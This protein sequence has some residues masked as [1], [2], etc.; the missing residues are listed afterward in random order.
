MLSEREYLTAGTS[1]KIICP[2]WETVRLIGR[3]SF[4]AVYEIQRDVFGHKEKAALKVLSIPPYDDFIEALYDEAYDD[5]DISNYLNNYLTD[6]LEVYS[7]NADVQDH[8]NVVSYDNIHYFRHDD[9]F[10]WNIYIKMELLTPITKVLDN[11][12]SDEQV[13]RLGKD[14]CRALIFGRS[15]NIAHGDITL[16]NIFISNAGNHKLGDFGIKKVV[17]NTLPARC[18]TLIITRHRKCITTSATD[19]W[20]ISTL[21]A[22]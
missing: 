22:W 16:Q 4:G 14:I 13:L 2:G 20:R 12:A 9:G 3:G 21:S 5:A 15:R 11:E 7:H 18:Q 1:E 19:P 17:K 8:P 6:F 10:G